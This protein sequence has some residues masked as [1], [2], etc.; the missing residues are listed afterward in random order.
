M[1]IIKI[2]EK[3]YGAISSISMPNFINVSAIVFWLA[4]Q[5]KWPELPKPT[6]AFFLLGSKFTK[7]SE[8]NSHDMN[9]YAKRNVLQYLL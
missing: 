3:H 6:S 4:L 1:C 5:P 7:Y 9:P 2:P 8:V